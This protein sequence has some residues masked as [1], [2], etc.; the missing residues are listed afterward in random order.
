MKVLSLILF[1][2]LALPLSS[3]AQ[4]VVIYSYD[5]AGNRSTRTSLIKVA[6]INDSP[7][8]E[9]SDIPEFD[10]EQVSVNKNNMLCNAFEA[11]SEDM[12]NDN[13]LEKNYWWNRIQLILCSLES[14][15][16]V[17][18]GIDIKQKQI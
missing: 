13:F 15:L 11:K 16:I 18:Q 7:I 10:F 4:T 9:E 6:A 14:R 8:L 12:H 1:I 17:S 2:F 3:R 5:D